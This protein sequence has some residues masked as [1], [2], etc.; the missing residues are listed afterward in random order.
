MILNVCQVIRCLIV[1]YLIKTGNDQFCPY[2][3]V[4]PFIGSKKEV[5]HPVSYVYSDDR[6]SV[7]DHLSELY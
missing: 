7:H 5:D 2:D 4:V 3:N 6:L 1:C